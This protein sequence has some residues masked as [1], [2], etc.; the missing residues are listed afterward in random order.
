MRLAGL[1][2]PL[3]R[4]LVAGVVLDQDLLDVGGRGDRL[5]ADRG[6]GVAF[7]QA[8]AGRRGAGQGARDAPP[9]PGAPEPPD[10]PNPADPVRAAPRAAAGGLDA[11]EGGVAD[12]DG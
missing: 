2:D 12:V 7:G 8:G 5:A 1:V 9:G 3:D 10:P 11:E 6:D 4:D